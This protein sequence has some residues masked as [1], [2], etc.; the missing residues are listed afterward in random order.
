MTAMWN[1]KSTRKSRAIP[2]ITTSHRSTISSTGSSVE[3]AN[4][5]D[6][7]SLTLANGLASL[8][9]E[10]PD[11]VETPDDGSGE[12]TDETSGPT[13]EV[14]ET[15]DAGDVVSI[16]VINANGATLTSSVGTFAESGTDTV[17]GVYEGSFNWQA[18][19]AVEDT[20]VRFLLVNPETLEWV[21]VAES[22]VTGNH[23]PAS[24]S[25]SCPT[26]LDPEVVTPIELSGSGRITVEATGG[27]FP[28]NPRNLEFAPD[29]D[30]GSTL[31]GNAPENGEVELYWQAPAVDE[32]TVFSI[33]ASDADGETLAS[34]DITLIAS[35]PPTEEVEEPGGGTGEGLPGGQ[36]AEST[37]IPIEEPGEEPTEGPVE[38]PAEEPEDQPSDDAIEEPTEETVDDSAVI[39]EDPAST[40]NPTRT[41]KSTATAK[42]DTSTPT[43]SPTPVATA[44]PTATS[45]PVTGPG[46]MVAEIIGPEG[47]QLSHPAGA[48]VIIPPGALTDDSTLTIML[49]EDAKLPVSDRVDFVSQTGFDI[50]IADAT[51]RPVDSLAKPATLK[52]ELKA[53]RWRRGT[54]LYWIHDSKTEVLS[55]VQLTDAAVSAPLDHF[56][57]FAAG[58]PI[59]GSE[60]SD[61]WK[62]LIAAV[63]GLVLVAICYGVFSASRR[64]RTLSVGTRR[65]PA[66]NRRR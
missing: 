60:S 50:S 7:D 8:A 19:N 65:V 45:G 10:N 66:R 46:G 44:Q 31:T 12:P 32:D 36:D 26:P 37:E 9:V 52:I 11:P 48:T 24:A 29:A 4:L 40:P 62:Y 6:T 53:D 34:C 41:P 59:T 14:P 27:S 20:Y 13:V 57:R 25:L 15:I 61:R 3:S 58:V 17:R 51:G 22:T 18:P 64:H 47:G 42:P 23:I 28:P 55:D 35:V 39:E 30:D 54:V 43:K 49:I 16:E 56:S 2:P 63:V 1:S 38:P 5:T 21:A 33:I